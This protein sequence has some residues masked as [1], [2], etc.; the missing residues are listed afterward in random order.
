MWHL[1]QKLFSSAGA[2][3]VDLRQLPSISEQALS[4]SLQNLPL[5]ERGWIRLAEAAHLFSRKGPDYAFGDIDDEGKMRLAEFAANC[6]CEFQFMP[7]EGR[8]YFRRR[9]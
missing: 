5:G 6:R 7:T 3:P 9:S 2:L 4:S 8:V 1:L